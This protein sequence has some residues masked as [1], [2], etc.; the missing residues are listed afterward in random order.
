MRAGAA[1]GVEHLRD[2]PMWGEG[3]DG[4]SMWD[5]PQRPERSP[6]APV[7]QVRPGGGAAGITLLGPGPLGMAA[8]DYL[9]GALP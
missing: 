7:R 3:T 5:S 4:R 8:L 6:S 1:S 9:V 2:Y